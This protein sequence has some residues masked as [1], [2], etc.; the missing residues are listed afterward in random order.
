MLQQK[1]YIDLSQAINLGNNNTR[2][3]RMCTFKLEECCGRRPSSRG[4]G[5]GLEA[6]QGEMMVA[7]ASGVKSLTLG[8]IFFQSLLLALNIVLQFYDN[9]HQIKFVN[10]CLLTYI[11]NFS[12]CN[13]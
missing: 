4:C 11:A 12:D 5:H 2:V 6:P 10:W 1:P 7:L 9:N 8:N 13:F 3:T